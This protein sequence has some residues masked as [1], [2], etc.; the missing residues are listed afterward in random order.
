M[1]V[2][3]NIGIIFAEMTN[4]SFKSSKLCEQLKE[5]SKNQSPFVTT[6]VVDDGTFNRTFQETEMDRRVLS[7]D[8]ITP[9][10]QI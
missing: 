1:I 7:I 9:L 5:C 4:N 2:E 6:L 10:P 8:L 3:P